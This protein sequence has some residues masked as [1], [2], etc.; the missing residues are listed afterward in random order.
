MAGTDVVLRRVGSVPGVME[1]QRLAG[2][3]ARSWRPRVL[4][5][6]RDRPGPAVLER[7]MAGCGELPTVPCSA[8]R[9]LCHGPSWSVR[10]SWPAPLSRSHSRGLVA[11]AGCGCDFLFSVGLSLNS[12]GATGLEA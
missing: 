5:G 6:C 11:L 4:R 2:D 1:Q 7:K 12:P 8:F 9:P 10:V 3:T